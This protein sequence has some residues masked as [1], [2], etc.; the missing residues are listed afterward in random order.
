MRSGDYFTWQCEHKEDDCISHDCCD[1]SKIILAPKKCYKL[2]FNGNIFGIS[3]SDNCKCNL[4]LRVKSSCSNCSKNIFEYNMPEIL[5][6]ETYT[7]VSFGG[8]FI[9]THDCFEPTILTLELVSP[10]KAIIKQAYL[11]IMEI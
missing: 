4:S 10:Y 6:G 8:I 5:N 2:F 3:C 1:H 9:S 7:T 11:S